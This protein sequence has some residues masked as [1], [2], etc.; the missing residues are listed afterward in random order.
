[1]SQ[2]KNMH[3]LKPLV[4]ANKNIIYKG[5]KYPID[6]NLIQNQSNY[7]YTNC[8][9]YANSQDIPLSEELID[10]SDESIQCF[11]SSCQN[12]RFEINDSN[13][14]ALHQLSIRYEVPCLKALTDEYI[15]EN[16]KTLILQSIQYNYKIQQ[17]S[18]SNATTN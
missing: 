6:F 13:V 12:E 3:F 18:D 15:K 16:N 11:I 14:F 10:I 5:K 1:M 9:K 2:S 4:R 7:F 17:Q 8:D